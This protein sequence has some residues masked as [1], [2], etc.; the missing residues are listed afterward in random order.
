MEESG[1]KMVSGDV[2]RP[3]KNAKLL[4]VQIGSGVQI[5]TSAFATLFFAAL[6]E[7]CCHKSFPGHKES[8]LLLFALSTYV[9]LYVLAYLQSFVHSISK[10]VLGVP[11]PGRGKKPECLQGF[12]RLPHVEPF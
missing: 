5:I 10:Y 11:S 8:A 7:C 12:C 3:P 2:F 9:W 4:C 6:G 1:W